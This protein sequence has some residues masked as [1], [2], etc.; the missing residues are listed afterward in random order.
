MTTNKMR[1]E[2]ADV[3]RRLAE[4]ANE[5]CHRSDGYEEDMQAAIL[6]ALLAA[7]EAATRRA[8]PDG[9]VPVPVEPTKAMRDAGYAHW[10]DPDSCI[11]ELYDAMLA[12][13]PAV[14]DEPG[15]E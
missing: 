12:A 3:A 6:A 2:L 10:G 14:A 8:L 9:F 11:T 5:C 1:E 13:R 7:S 4:K 15:R